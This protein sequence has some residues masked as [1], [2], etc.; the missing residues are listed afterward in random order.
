LQQRITTR[1][2]G[3][4]FLTATII[5]QKLPGSVKLTCPENLCHIGRRLE[6]WKPEDLTYH[7]YTYFALN[8]IRGGGRGRRRF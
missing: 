5:F 3:V 1:L 4:H 6:N 7:G 2:L 8:P